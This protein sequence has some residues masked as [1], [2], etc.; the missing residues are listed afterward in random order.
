[1]KYPTAFILVL[2]WLAGWTGST[3][4]AYPNTT[5]PWWI[6]EVDSIRDVGEGLAITYD[7]VNDRTLI[8]YQDAASKTLWLAVTVDSHGN[9]GPDD[10]WYCQVLDDTV[11]VGQNLSIDA[12]ADELD[13]NRTL[14]YVSYYDSTHAALKYIRGMWMSHACRYAYPHTISSGD[15]DWGIYIGRR[16]A[17][18]LDA[19]LEVHIAYQVLRLMGDETVM[20]ATFVFQGQ[21]TE[22]CGEGDVENQWTCEQII[23]A[24]GVGNDISLDLDANDHAH[25]A[26]YDSNLGYPVMVLESSK[27]SGATPST[28]WVFHTVKNGSKITGRSIS[29]WIDGNNQDHLAYYNVTDA[30]LEYA[31]HV[32]SGGNCGFSSSTMHWEWQC[33]WIDDMGSVASGPMGI[34]IEGDSLDHPVIAYEDATSAQ[35]PPMLKLARPYAAMSDVTPNCG[36]NGGLLFEWFCEALDTGGAWT[37]EASSIAM[38]SRR[39]MISIAYR[40]QNNYSN[41]PTGTLKTAVEPGESIFSDNFE[42]GNANAWYVGGS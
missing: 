11:A 7:H 31:T 40:E 25:I 6:D 10:S 3:Q 22:N 21:G 18:K 26:Y 39:G 15:P 42:C 24:S 9:C 2:V 38:T 36:P 33:D 16:S 4:A 37:D 13:P 32:G 27:S 23:Q 8:A 20:Y 19:S 35:G 1:M 12:I 34:A 28:S 5:I 30:T 14:Y 41:P 17:L 29:L